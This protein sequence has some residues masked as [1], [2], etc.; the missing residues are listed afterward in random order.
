MGLSTYYNPANM[1]FSDSSKSEFEIN[2]TLILIPTFDFDTENRDRGINVKGSGLVGLAA[3]GHFCEVNGQS[4]KSVKQPNPNNICGNSRV[5]GNAKL[6]LQPVPKI[7]I[8]SRSLALPFNLKANYGFSFTTPS[9]LSMQWGGQG[10]GFL[11][12]ISIAMLELNPVASIA[13]KDFIAFGAG[14]RAIYLWT[15]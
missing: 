8:K 3:S 10:G 9:G 15:I 11:K 1:S 5:L 12:D 4:Q 6:T 14:F 2:G 7:F 13:W